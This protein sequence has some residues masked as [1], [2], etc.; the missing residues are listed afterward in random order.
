MI[1]TVGLY[2]DQF[3]KSLL[4]F[5]YLGPARSLLSL[6]FAKYPA[7]VFHHQQLAVLDLYYFLHLGQLN[8]VTERRSGLMQ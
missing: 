4:K 1:L 6:D 7:F 2:Q 5:V 3:L 8:L